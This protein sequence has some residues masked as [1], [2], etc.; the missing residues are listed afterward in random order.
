MAVID[1]L[2]GG[3]AHTVTFLTYDSG[4]RSLSLASIGVNTDTTSS[5][6]RG[7]AH[8]TTSAPDVGDL[9]RSQTNDSAGRANL[10]DSLDTTQLHDKDR[11]ARQLYGI[12][13][14]ISTSA[15]RC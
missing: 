11:M 3:A 5:F 15:W 10:S 1:S 2:R 6:A 4:Y 12:I 14:H 9:V 7:E 8:G 13:S